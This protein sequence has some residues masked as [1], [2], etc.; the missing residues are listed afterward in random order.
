MSVTY[1][2]VDSP[3]GELTITAEGEAVTGVHFAGTVGDPASLGN[4]HDHG[5][6]EVTRQLREYFA[7]QRTY[8]DLPLEPRGH[9]FERRV[10]EVLRTIPYGQTRSYGQ[11]AEALGEPGAA[12]AVGAANGRNP[13]PVLIPCHR[14]IGADGSLTGFAGGLDRKRFLLRLEEP[15]AAEA[16]RLF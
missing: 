2:V 16:G 4:R 7:G 11:I 9:D 14:V 6:R 5:F 15:S 8:F 13:L 1:T 10:W 3:I 12:Q